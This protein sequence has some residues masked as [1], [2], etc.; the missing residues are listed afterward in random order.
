[1]VVITWNHGNGILNSSLS[2]RRFQSAA[3]YTPSGERVTFDFI[4]TELE[5]T[6]AIYSNSLQGIFELQE[7]IYG[8]QR[9]KCTVETGLHSIIGHFPVSLELI[10]TTLNKLPR[11]KGTICVLTLSTKINYP[12]IV[13]VRSADTGIIEEI[14]LEI[15]SKAYTDKDGSLS[16]DTR[17]TPDQHAVLS[18]DV[19]TEETHTK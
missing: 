4:N 3:D 12:V 17:V 15:D 8:R 19:I 7:N 6:M 1:M 9:E 10:N 13:N 16:L 11:D 2:R 18:R 5:L 14:H